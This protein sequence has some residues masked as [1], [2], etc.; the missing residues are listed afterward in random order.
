MQTCSDKR[1]GVKKK[2]K[3][4]VW[5]A[6][7]S[8]EWHQ[9][10]RTLL[11]YKFGMDAWTNPFPTSEGLCSWEVWAGHCCNNHGTSW[12][13]E[14]KKKLASSRRSCSFFFFFYTWAPCVHF[15]FLVFSAEGSGFAHCQLPAQRNVYRLMCMLLFESCLMRALTV[16]AGDFG[17]SGCRRNRDRGRRLCLRP[18]EERVREGRAVDTWSCCRAPR[19]RS[20]GNAF[21]CL[22]PNMTPR[23]V[24]PVVVRFV[25]LAFFQCGSCTG[26]S[27]EQAP[28]SCRRSLSTQVTTNWRTEATLSVSPWVQ[29][30]W[31]QLL[32][33][34]SSS[35][36]E[37]GSLAVVVVVVAAAEL[38]QNPS[39]FSMETWHLAEF[40]AF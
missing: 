28:M 32:A 1:G 35:H 21:L 19:S 23:P 7:G 3:L 18:G 33:A 30:G 31:L 40:F 24:N 5:E 9:D 39:A 27:W 2:K 12:S 38:A 34:L 20:V 15:S 26:S 29:A 14:G 13:K 36:G 11:D 6:G 16:N 37:D 4:A 10:H 22:S 8:S 17:A 25:C